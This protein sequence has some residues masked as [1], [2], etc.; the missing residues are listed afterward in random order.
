MNILFCLG[1]LE[2]GGTGRVVAHL[3]NYLR[4]KTHNVFIMTT[5]STVSLYELDSSIKVFSLKNKDGIGLL[6][7]I[8]RIKTIVQENNIS[9]IVAMGPEMSIK[10]L[11]LKTIYR[12]K[13]IVS[14]RANPEKELKNIWYNI[15]ARLFY[16]F[17]DAI[18]FQTNE[19]SFYFSRRCRRIAHI[20]SNPV[21]D[22]FLSYPYEEKKEKKI[23]AVGRLTKDKNYPLL[24]AAFSKLHIK[25]PE[26][27]LVILGDGEEYD[28]LTQLADQYKISKHVSFN[29]NIK[30][31]K[32]IVSQ[33]YMFALCSNTEGMPNA[34]MEA[35]ALG[36]VCIS[37]DCPVGGPRK[38]INN[39]KNGFLIPVNSDI[40][41]EKCMEF[42]I[43]NPDL[44]RKISHQAKRDMEAYSLKYV[45]K[46]W[47]KFLLQINN[48]NNY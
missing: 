48:K 46:E 35:M 6:K 18:I 43:N 17:S 41:L 12:I 29:G 30:D 34:L 22:E 19:A 13:V 3:S 45:G 33:S 28:L 38:L 10:S 9:L 24:L 5:R 32:E 2:K 47:E 40:D 37:T 39:E 42:C 44:C 36:T 27:K 23:V 16:G 25:F 31:I 26:Y 21:S 11:L 8:N 20:L 7:Q 15:A 1:S 4:A 14:V